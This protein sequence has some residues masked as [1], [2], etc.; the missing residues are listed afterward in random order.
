MTIIK[1][2]KYNIGQAVRHKAY[3]FAGIVE[4]VDP[5]FCG[6][7]DWFDEIPVEN[8]PDRDQPFY[9]VRVDHRGEE[10]VAYVSE[11]NL[12]PDA[13]GQDVPVV[14]ATAGEAHAGTV[15][16]HLH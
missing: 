13:A 2:A 16:I 8:R 11:Q 5:V 9:R 1:T 15:A 10:A 3:D 14:S 12:I 4:D 7:D 6:T